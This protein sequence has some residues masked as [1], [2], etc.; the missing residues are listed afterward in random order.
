MCLIRC[1]FLFFLFFF[2]DRY[3]NGE[4]QEYCAQVCLNC[5]VD[6]R[7]PVGDLFD[8]FVVCVC[9][10]CL[11]VYAHFVCMCVCMCV[12]IHRTNPG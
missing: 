5:Y 12:C 1:F 9:T 11:Y 2:A 8:F 10:F 4:T 6:A 3:G 7:D